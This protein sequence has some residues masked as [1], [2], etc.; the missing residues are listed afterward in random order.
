MLKRMPHNRR[1]IF[2]DPPS[3]LKSHEEVVF[4]LKRSLGEVLDAFY[5]LAGRIVEPEAEGRLHLACNDEGAAFREAVVVGGRTGGDSD[6]TLADLRDADAF[7]DRQPPFFD[8][9]I[10]RVHPSDY[11]SAPPLI[12]QVRYA[13]CL[14]LCLTTTAMRRQKGRHTNSLVNKSKIVETTARHEF[15]RRDSRAGVEVCLRRRC[16]RDRAQPRGV[17]W[18]LAMALYGVVGG[19]RAWGA[20]FAAPAARAHTAQ[21]RRAVARQGAA[22][23]GR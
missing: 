18:E 3:P 5:P 2:Y 1:V 19:V 16:A 6:I 10:P 11:A 12:V 21:D 23:A 20:D 4:T 7:S 9:L 8:Q 14:H 17:R 15:L 13:E 22:D